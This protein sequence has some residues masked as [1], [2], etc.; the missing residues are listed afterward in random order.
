M[1]AQEQE[2]SREVWRGLKRL[3]QALE[4][5]E[6]KGLR[7][8]VVGGVGIFMHYGSGF[9]PLRENGTVRD[10]DVIILEDPVNLTPALEAVAQEMGIPAS[11]TSAKQAQP[12]GERGA[13]FFQIAREITKAQGGEEGAYSFSFRDVQVKIPPEVFALEH[14]K[15]VF[16]GEEISFPTF[17][18][19]TILHLYITRTGS[20]KPKD[21]SKLR[22]YARFLR[23]TG[24]YQKP[25]C[26]HDLYRGFHEFAHK[27]NQHYPAYRTAM[28]FYHCLDQVF[29]G[30]LTQKVIPQWLFKLLTR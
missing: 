22:N 20:L 26:G 16:G 23:K 29:G 11:F 12:E 14:K 4:D 10:L 7:A 5:A 30:M 24:A 28:R 15:L 9:T 8:A 1:E 19:L 13:S 27:V 3:A 25:D 18:A 2:R 21:L 6:R 17:P